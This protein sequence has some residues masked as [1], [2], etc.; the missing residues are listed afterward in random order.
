MAQK[1][2]V[3]T[4]VT[5]DGTNLAYDSNRQPVYTES[6]VEVAARPI[7]ESLNA[8][9]P[10]H[11]RH[12]LTVISEKEPKKADNATVEKMKAKDAEIAALKKQLQDDSLKQ[13]I[14]DRDVEIAALKKQLE[15]KNKQPKPAKEGEPAKNDDPATGK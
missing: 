1:L 4:P 13:A 2:K 15:E 9:L 7:F 10:E 12:E 6:I 5:T 11:L 14:A 8:G 3:K